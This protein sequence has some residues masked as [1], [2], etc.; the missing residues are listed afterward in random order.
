MSNKGKSVP[1][2]FGGYTH[3]D[4]KGHKIGRS[5]PNITGG[6][7][8]YDAKGNKIGHSSPKVFG[9]YT[10]YDKKGHK[11][12]D[13]RP[14]VFDSTHYDSR[15]N[16]VGTSRPNA[17]GGFTHTDSQ[18]CYIATCVYGSY[19]CPEVW[20]LRRFRDDTLAKS[21][22]GR[23]FIHTYYAISPTLVRWFGHT[24]L[25]QRFWKRHLNKLVL[26]LQENGVKDTPYQD[27]DYNIKRRTR[28]ESNI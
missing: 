18:G 16:K 14:G 15:G 6:F 9:G 5:T 23:L 8:N 27:K 28:H 20:T 22:A 3:Y 7:T 17:T 11:I 25:F 13:T 4:S 10:H 12:G 21:G 2:I 19:D 26:S 24:S 1:D